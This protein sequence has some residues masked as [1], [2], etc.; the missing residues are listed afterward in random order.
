MFLI[1]SFFFKVRFLLDQEVRLVTLN[2]QGREGLFNVRN[3]LL[4]GGLLLLD[5]SV[6]ELLEGLSGWDSSLGGISQ[7]GGG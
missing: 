7:K 1:G 4:E 3:L 5:K 2:V 6:S